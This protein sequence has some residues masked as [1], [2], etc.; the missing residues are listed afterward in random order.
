MSRPRFRVEQQLPVDERLAL[1]AGLRQ[2]SF[3]GAEL[4]RVDRLVAE[5]VVDDRDVPRLLTDPALPSWS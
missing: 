5:Q 2:L 1:E 3:F 4:S